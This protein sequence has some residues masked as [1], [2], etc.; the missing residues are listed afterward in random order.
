MTEK[1]RR[2]LDALNE[3]QHFI[4]LI[5]LARDIRRLA[6]NGG[7]NRGGGTDVELLGHADYLMSAALTSLGEQWSSEAP[8]TRLS[9]A[10][11]DDVLSEE[12]LAKAEKARED[13]ER[14]LAGLFDDLCK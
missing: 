13:S 14:D 6:R 1:E 3:I 4:R 2:G 12:D 7:T 10:T 5:D 9:I 8:G 11:T